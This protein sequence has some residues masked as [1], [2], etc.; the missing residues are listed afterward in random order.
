MNRLFSINFSR[1]LIRCSGKNNDASQFLQGMITN[2]MQLLSSEIGYKKC[3][4]TL[5]LNKLGRILYDSIIYKFPSTSKEEELFLIECD[6]NVAN[7]LIRHLKLYRVRRKIDIILSDEHDLYCF[8]SQNSNDLKLSNGSKYFLDPR[9]K[10][11]GAR[12]ITNKNHNLKDD[13]G[14]DVVE[15]S[16]EEYISH[17]YK[18][19][20]CEGIVDLPPEKAFPLESNCDYMNGVSF[21]KGCY[22]GQELTARTHHTG[23]IRKRIMPL[24]FEMP[25]KMNDSIDVNNEDK[26]SVGKLRNISEIYGLGLMRVE[27][28]LAAKELSYNENKCMIKK[29]FWWPDD[30][31]QNSSN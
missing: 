9:L 3:I 4:Y 7:N 31:N 11:I 17:R 1:S 14:C 21:H 23:V 22:L 13:I 26:K 6:K 10:D 19:G 28:A 27:Q 29:P 15:G 18:L 12:I 20:I 16:N 24:I 30:S 5:F 8:H 2:D 25:I